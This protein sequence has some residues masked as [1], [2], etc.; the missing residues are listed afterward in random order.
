MITDCGFLRLIPGVGGFEGGG[1]KQYRNDHPLKTT[2]FHL[3]DVTERYKFSMDVRLVTPYEMENAGIAEWRGQRR[4]G[5]IGPIRNL[6]GA[7]GL[8]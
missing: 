3:Q 5:L 2:V 4:L 8:R 6:F 7:V 1:A